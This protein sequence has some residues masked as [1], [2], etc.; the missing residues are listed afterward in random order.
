[1]LTAKSV[2]RRRFTAWLSAFALAAILPL[3]AARAA[4]IPVAVA[5]NFTA[6]AKELAANFQLATGNTL[7]LSFGAS[8][9]FFT[10]IGQG[11]PFEIFLSA[12]SARPKK[13]V[14]SGLGVGGSEFTY[15]TGKLVLWSATPGLVDS[16][17]KVLSDGKFAHLAIAAPKSAPYGEAAIETMKALNVYDQLQSRIVVGESINQAYQFTASGSAELGFV[18]YSQVIKSKKGSE[19]LVPQNLYK[20]ITQDAVLL[21]TGENDPAAQAFLA[22]LKTPAAL[23]IIRSYGYVTAP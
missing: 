15:A 17:G 20:P 23:K 19:W 12:D 14:E 21:K 9:A 6:P 18:A 13:L 7:V 3:N 8:G 2:A 5:A 16:Q 10:Q 11:A 22:Y 4:S 1:M